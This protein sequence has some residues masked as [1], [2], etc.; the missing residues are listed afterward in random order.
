LMPVCGAAASSQKCGKAN[1]S[2][3]L[4][5]GFG[6]EN[7][8]VT[9]DLFHITV[10]NGDRASLTFLSVSVGGIVQLSLPRD[11][12]IPIP[13]AQGEVHVDLRVAILRKDIGDHGTLM[14]SPGGNMIAVHAEDS[15]RNCSEKPIAVSAGVT[16]LHAVIVGINNYHYD[17]S[18]DASKNR[19]IQLHWARQDAE[20][21]ASFLVDSLGVPP[22]NIILL[23]EPVV[24][25]G[26][27]D[28]FSANR[29][30]P[31]RAHILGAIGDL[32]DN[33]DK[34]GTFLF[35]FSG[36]GY[37]NAHSKAFSKQ[38]YF[39]TADSDTHNDVNMISHQDLDEK[40]GL[41]DTEHKIII[42]D[43]CFSGD[44]IISSAGSGVTSKG[45]AKGG[46]DFQLLEDI[47]KG[48][49]SA[50]ASDGDHLSYEFDDLHHSVFTYYL[51]E[52]ASKGHIDPD[53]GFVTIEQAYQHSLK[54]VVRYITKQF[55][56]T[57]QVPQHHIDGNM[58]KFRW[59]KAVESRRSNK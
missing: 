28:R 33:F 37:L 14:L 50:S 42:A 7:K 56:E 18:D 32:A 59:S 22:G 4:Q 39:L 23:T 6:S 48:S 51:L 53:T 43:S 12:A 2:I 30:S 11:G 5:A 52:G 35:Y 15:R 44:E 29:N 40:I 26:G 41:I 57:V 25:S 46:T 47:A 31:T 16:D 45:T 10:Q 58:D 17:P 9:N 36:H 1:P 34:R 49:Y 24:V 38:R 13:N 27:P 55:G 3:F 20:D 8:V 54:E 21:V 19:K